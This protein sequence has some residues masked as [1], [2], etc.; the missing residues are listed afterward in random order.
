MAIR[1]DVVKGCAEEDTNATISTRAQKNI[2][3]STIR[4][5][6]NRTT[7][8]NL[9]ET[10]KRH[11][12][13]KL[14]NNAF[15]LATRAN[16]HRHSFL[17]SGLNNVIWW[18]FVSTFL[19]LIFGQLSTV[20]LAANDVLSKGGLQGE[21]N[22]N[23]VAALNG[24]PTFQQEDEEEYPDY[25]LDDFDSDAEDDEETI[26]FYSESGDDDITCLPELENQDDK[27]SYLF[28]SKKAGYL[29][30][31]R[32]APSYLFRSRRAPSYLFRSRRSPDFAKKAQGYLFRSRRAPSYLFRSRKAPSYLFR[33]RRAPSYLFRSKKSDGK[34]S[35]SYFFRSRKAP[36]YLFRSRRSKGYL[37]RSRREEQTANNMKN[38]NDPSIA[39]RAGYL[40]RTRKSF[41]TEMSDAQDQAKVDLTGNPLTRQLRSR[42][43]LFRS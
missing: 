21:A 14:R 35:R 18:A 25:T 22:T 32:R 40:F 13:K 11:C 2:G 31:S 28:R 24:N 23:N 20:A 6:H 38:D 33:S 19:A 3:P 15:S 10:T 30:R 16:T 7:K 42:S 12:E 36:G 1:H 5:L 37:F 9:N 27:R 43:Y 17:R 39:T 26:C 41:P 34:Q 29:F 4:S 8:V